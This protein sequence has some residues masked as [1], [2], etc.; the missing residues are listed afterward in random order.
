MA[1]L[2]TQA[3]RAK[4]KTLADLAAQWGTQIRDRVD[5]GFD[6]ATAHGFKGL[7]DV[8]KSATE[9]RPTLAAVRKSRSFQA[10]NNRLGELH[11][12][13]V[14]LLT[15]ARVEL[16]TVAFRGWRQV[17]PPDVMRPGADPT[18]AGI[19]RFRVLMIGALT[20]TDDLWFPIRRSIETLEQSLT[21]AGS[22]ATAATHAQDLVTQWGQKARAGVL[23]TAQAALEDAMHRADYVAGRDVLR[24]ELLEPDPTLGE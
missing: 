10:G 6:D 21:I 12:A 4:D 17:F 2:N 3:I 7:T 15:D 19:D 16:Y 23:N 1:V 22:Q 24:P 14:K 11:D 13:L 5:L 18:Q 9:G 8:V 20:L